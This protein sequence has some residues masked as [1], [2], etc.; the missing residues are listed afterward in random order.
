MR[1][2]SQSWTAIDALQLP[3][4]SPCSLPSIS[5]AANGSVRQFARSPTS[6]VSAW[7]LNASDGLP[8]PI[9]PTALAT[10]SARDSVSVA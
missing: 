7:A 9:R 4:P 6:T 2:A 5:V 10:P 8:S 3:A 1:S